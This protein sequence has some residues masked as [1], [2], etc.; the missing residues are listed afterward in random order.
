ML[1]KE[2]VDQ[3]EILEHS[4]V[5]GFLS[6]CGWNSVMES[7]CANV[8]ILAWPIM[9]EQSLNAKM[10][11]VEIGIGLRVETSNGFVSW[12]HLKKMVKD[13]KTDEERRIEK[14]IQVEEADQY[15]DGIESLI[16]RVESLLSEG[17]LCEAADALE[18]VLK[19]AGH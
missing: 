10:V 9:A 6:Q 17:K 14:K 13:E 11:V 2:W 4:S 8:P 18:M 12:E 3:R 19:A 15:G 1:V 5:Q 7:I 16:N